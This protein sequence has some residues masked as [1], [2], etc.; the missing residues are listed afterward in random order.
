MDKALAGILVLA[1][2]V[3][4]FGINHLL[5]DDEAINE[6]TAG[7]IAKGGYPEYQDHPPA[8]PVSFYLFSQARNALSGLGVSPP[9]RL[10]SVLYGLLLIALTFRFALLAFDRKTAIISSAIIAFSFY[11]LLARNIIDIDGNLLT[12]LI[13]ASLYFYYRAHIGRENRNSLLAMSGIFFGLAMLTKYTAIAI[14]PAIAVFEL[15]GGKKPE[16]KGVAAAA[17]IGIALFA[18]FPAISFATGNESVFLKTIEWGGKNVSGGGNIPV[19]TA[20]AGFKHVYRIAEYGGP[21]LFFLPL[22]GLLSKQRKKALIFWAFAIAALAMFILLAQ[23]GQIERNQMIILPALS[24]LAGAVAAE[25]LE[26]LKKNIHVIAGSALAFAAVLFAFQV[27]RLH[28]TFSIE[29]FDFALAL[30]NPD[31]WL[32]GTSGP[33]VIMALWGLLFT[34]IAALVLS[35]VFLLAKSG[36]A[37]ALAL[38][39]MIGLGIAFNAV[40]LSEYLFFATTPDYNQT[41]NGMAEFFHERGGIKPVFST[42]EDLAFYAGEGFGSFY[43]LDK[44]KSMQMLEGGGTA[45]FLNLPPRRGNDAWLELQKKCPLAKTFYSKGY[46]TGFVFSCPKQ[47][48]K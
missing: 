4:L 7:I 41:M 1:L 3:S 36:K 28:E 10:L 11:G 33:L 37:K 48:L 38:A 35:A 17:A 13:T 45:L 19:E 39:L 14:I 27:F 21:L 25:N 2:A 8:G 26:S 9:I 40:L 24:I 42:N 6:F 30:K 12:L 31:V 29:H 22:L 47:Q 20:K 15:L 23:K 43:H 44:S 16:W 32:A 46:E 5:V 18:I 34:T